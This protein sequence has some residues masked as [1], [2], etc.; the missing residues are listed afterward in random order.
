MVDVEKWGL[1]REA[2]QYHESDESV[3]EGLRRNGATDDEIK[4]LATH[5]VELN[6]FASDDP[7][8][9]ITAKLEKHGVQKVI[10]TDDVLAEGYRRRFQPAYLGQH[11]GDLLERPRE[12]IRGIK[13]PSDLREQVAGLLQEQPTLSWDDAVAEIVSDPA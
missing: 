11:F 4:F 10:P 1:E 2:V 8:R 3:R 6:A 5:R 13:I 7:V 9:W 12:H